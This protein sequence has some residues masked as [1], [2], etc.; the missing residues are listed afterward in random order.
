MIALLLVQTAPAMEIR[1]GE[2]VVIRADIEIHDDLYVFG[3]TVQIDGRVH[4]DVFA[5]AR[6]V[7]VSGRID[8]D[9]TVAARRVVLGGAVNDARVAAQTL[10]L[11]PRARVS[12]DA[13]AATVEL[14]AQ[15]GSAV[16]RDLIALAG[17]IELSGEIGRH[18]RI[19]AEKLA[20]LGR[21]DVRLLAPIR[22]RGAQ[23]QA[24]L[25]RIRSR[26]VLVR[27]RA[28]LVNHARSIVKALER[29]H[30]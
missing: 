27:T 16:G 26:D 7:S 21:Y 18:A 19:D 2:R 23:A 3:S 5:V 30:T 24:D 14:Y 11:P 17:E 9:L 8:G 1:S 15:P 28:K 10:L 4:G 20:R 22:H 12:G 6:E 25:A 13:L 29:K